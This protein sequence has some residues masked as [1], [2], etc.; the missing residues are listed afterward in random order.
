MVVR[1]GVMEKVK[2]CF[3]C[4]VMLMSRDCSVVGLLLCMMDEVP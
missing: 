2:V 3:G 1:I 4:A